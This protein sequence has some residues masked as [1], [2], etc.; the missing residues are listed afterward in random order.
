VSKGRPRSKYLP[1]FVGGAFPDWYLE[2]PCIGLSDLMFNEDRVQ[3]AKSVC[4]R[5]PF[6]EPCLTVALENHESWGVWGMK[7]PAERLALV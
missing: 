7:T 5:C 2:A 6:Q 1:G 3:E 4:K